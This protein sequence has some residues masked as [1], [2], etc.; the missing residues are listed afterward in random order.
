MLLVKTWTGTPVSVNGL[1]ALGSFVA[2]GAALWISVTDR[3][4]TDDAR[5]QEHAQEAS[6]LAR[7]AGLVQVTAEMLGKRQPIGPMIPTPAIGGVKNRRTDRIFDIG[8]VAKFI[9]GGE[10]LELEIASVNGFYVFP[11]RDGSSF[12]VAEQ[13]RGLALETDDLL[14]LYQQ[15]SLPNTPADFAAVRYTDSAGRRWE[16]DTSGAVTRL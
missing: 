1:G 5:A 6:D 9:H 13:L 2:A 14:V 15:D 3:R 4:R 12:H 11:Q 7:Q 8:G 10:T 16:V